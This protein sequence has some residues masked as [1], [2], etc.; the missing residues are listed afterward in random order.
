MHT[1]VL[2]AVYRKGGIDSIISLSQ[3]LASVIE[4][5]TQINVE[6]RSDPDT[7]LL[8]AAQGGLKFALHL[9]HP[10]IM[11]KPLHDSPQTLLLINTDKKDA[12]YFEPH[13]FI[14]KLRLLLLPL[15]KEL[16]ESSW[17][18]SAP[19]GVTRSITQAVLELFYIDGEVKPATT[20][21]S[22]AGISAAL[23]AATGLVPRQPLPGPDE[24]RIRQLTDMGFPRS[25]AE[26]ALMRA[27]NNVSAAAELLVANPFPF[28]PDPEPN[29]PAAPAA[30][31][32]TEENAAEDAEE[33]GGDTDV[34]AEA[35]AGPSEPARPQEVEEAHETPEEPP[36]EEEP[37][38]KTS[39]ELRKELNDARELLKE[40]LGRRALA[41]VDEHDSL[42]FDVQRIF[43]GPSSTHRD[44]S[45]KCITDDIKAFSTSAYDHQEHPMAVRCRIL[46]MIL[47][48]PTSP[49]S[50]MPEADA[51]A[52]MSD[53]L[54]LLLSNPSAPETG[55]PTIP[56]WLAAHLLV[57]EAILVAGSEPREISVPREDEPIVKEVIEVGPLYPE[58]RS[59][60]FDFCLR[61]LVIP[62]LPRDELLSI[63]RIFVLLTRDHKYAGDFVKRDGIA[64]LFR[65]IK[66][67]S[68][69]TP[70]GMHPY[71]AMILRHVVEDTATVQ[72]IMR[73]EIKRY[74]ANPRNRAIEPSSFV[75]GCG[76][77]ALRDPQ[78]FIRVTE[79]LCE[80][81][82]PYSMVKNIFLKSTFSQSSSSAN[83]PPA[84]A[85][86]GDMQVDE[87]T[88]TVS[89]SHSESLD[90]LVHFLVGELIKS[91]R[92]EP[93]ADSSGSNASKPLQSVTP[94]APSD[95]DQSIPLAS[96]SKSSDETPN[97]HH[98]YVF[99]CFLM[100]TLTELLF[101]YDSCKLAFLS[102]SPK[103]RIHTPAKESVNKHR[104]AALQFLISELM[105][106]GTLNPS[107][108][109][110]AKKQIMLCNW[111]MS[112]IV[113]LCVDT[114]PTQDIKDVPPDRVS[115]R[116]FVLEALSRAIKDLPAS[117][118]AEARYS[119]LLALSDLC[120]R[121]ISVR[122]NSGSRK[123]NDDTPT[124][125]AKVMLEKNFV[126]TLTNALAEV[127]LN[128][129]NIRSVVAGILR[130]LEY[131]YVPQV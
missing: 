111:A 10:I 60:L 22:A 40:G 72:H 41:L 96:E 57:V 30:A 35:E 115:V 92:G 28:P 89:S 75:R 65:C 83:A 4:E 64:N 120:Y 121:L 29:E 119:R 13:D 42:V 107:P 78:A 50:S 122:F 49:L 116:R 11:S 52:L 110:D 9:I 86:T 5:I 38:G 73:Q 55:H 114:F 16:W 34:S 129:P 31:E 32:A 67:L 3:F 56:K 118:S 25:A 20:D 104:T 85:P 70:P 68:G 8:V 44:Q 99:S 14:V 109:P 48:D 84:V 15:L 97:R 43:V 19:L 105:T 6:D 2:V 53:L 93:A 46:A 71:I 131:L 58:A 98:D 51:K 106:F 88:N 90:S 101:S 45:V 117:D 59:I 94:F 23:A 39:E 102:Y 33:A 66:Q 123:S 76:S 54:A 112:V 18:I 125:L 74:F 80:M 82:S 1:L 12:D 77:M 47:G 37:A 21:T 103:K 130:P 24:N 91:V 81:K 17:L 69:S 128:Y 113:A 108:P 62:S 79:E 95:P 7:Q 26:R 63:L 87:P 61:V 36:K 27:R 127:D 124:H 126:A 100:Q